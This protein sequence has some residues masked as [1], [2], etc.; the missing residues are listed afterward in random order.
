MRLAAL[1]AEDQPGLEEAKV[2]EKKV[3]LIFNNSHGRIGADP[4]AVCCTSGLYTWA[5]GEDGTTRF[6][7]MNQQ[8]PMS[9]NS[10]DNKSLNSG[11]SS[12]L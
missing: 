6:V 3:A 9:P 12:S 2:N 4:T 1:V 7:V 8:L 11:T 5:K 10:S